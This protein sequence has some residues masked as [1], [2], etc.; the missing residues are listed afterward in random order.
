M[1]LKCRF[2]AF[3]AALASLV[4]ADFAFAAEPLTVQSWIALGPFPNPESSNA[5]SDCPRSGYAEDFLAPLGGEA[6]AVLSLESVRSFPESAGLKASV[7]KASGGM[8]DFRPEFKETEYKAA[9][10]YGSLTLDEPRELFFEFGSDD[11]AKVWINGVLVHEIAVKS[12]GVSADSDS[13]SSKLPKG[14][15]HILVKV[16]NGNGGWGFSLKAFDKET[17]AARKLSRDLQDCDVFPVH[18]D[19]YVFRGSKF[20]KLTWDASAAVCQALG[21]SSFEPRWFDGKLNELKK[22]ETPGRYLAYVEMTRPDGSKFRRALTVCKQPERLRGYD[23]DLNFS[24][25]RPPKNSGVGK[26]AWNSHLEVLNIAAES[27]FIDGF[28]NSPDGASLLAYALEM[29]QTD[30]PSSVLDNPWIAGA[31]AQLA[32]KRKLLGVGPETFKQLQAPSAC[33]PEA[34]VLRPG[35]AQEAGMKPESVAKLREVCSAWAQEGGEPFVAL[36]ARNGV[37]FFHEAFGKAELDEKFDAASITKAVSGML[38]AQF[39]DQGIMKPDDP[40]GKYLPDFPTSGPKAL[41]LRNCLTHTSGLNGHFEWGGVHNPWLDNVIAND[42]GKIEPG[43]A[44]NYNGMGFDLAGKAMEMAAGKSV[45]RCFQENL[46]LPLGIKNAYQWDMACAT[47]FSA[48]DFAKF[49]QTLLN[50]GSYGSARFFSPE[51]FEQIAPRDLS[52]FY[53]GVNRVYGF[54]LDYLYVKDPDAGKDGL[55]ADKI[56]L[57][58]R[59][60]GHGAASSSVMRADL[61]HGLAI[62]VARNS[63]GRDYPQHLAKFLKALEAGLK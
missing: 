13:F 2:F 18:R 45:L 36:V 22:P 4:A 6:S 11:S 35:T 49:A 60:L 14:E 48:E 19:R 28:F 56:L 50:R 55:P 42:L 54:G 44:Y 3:F 7:V 5:K 12:R 37:V 58:N 51:A 61:D 29:K 8:L 47:D 40:L 27:V 20:P 25:P 31:E 23:M 10:A 59:L 62:A 46:F 9:Y 43:K 32:L 24:L 21:S 34:T 16:E 1:K 39:I 30:T 38:F 53:P 15:S 63:S 57:G 33:S 41:T 52:A 26:A 17:L